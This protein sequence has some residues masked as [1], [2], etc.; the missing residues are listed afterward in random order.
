MNKFQLIDTIITKVDA[1]ADARGVS[2]CV[3][4]VDIVQQLNALRD[5]L[6][7][8]GSRHDDPVE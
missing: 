5:L 6:R 3:M 1:L 8:E 4:V 7:E 2:R